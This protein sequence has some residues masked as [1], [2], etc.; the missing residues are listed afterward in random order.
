MFDGLC[1]MT[2]FFAGIVHTGKGVTCSDSSFMD[3]STAE[4]CSNAVNYAKSFNSN[5]NYRNLGS[6][7][8][9]PKGCFI[10]DSG[11]MF[12]NTHLTGGRTVSYTHLTLP[13]KRIV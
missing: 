1:I 12:F 13:T 2:S 9:Y 8:N 7:S 10:Y 6:W 5:A 4:E 3:L 11:R